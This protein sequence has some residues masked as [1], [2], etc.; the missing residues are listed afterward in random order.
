VDTNGLPLITHT[1]NLTING[2]GATI[3]RDAGAPRFRLFQVAAGASLTLADLTL[4]GGHTPDGT[5]AGTGNAGY[6]GA[7]LNSGGTVTVTNSLIRG[8]S[9]GNGG[10]C[11]S[12]STMAGV[13]LARG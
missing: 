5:S 10:N 13:V 6:G 7:I 9:T 1:V 4:S 3:L 12:E 2:S 11:C 8:N